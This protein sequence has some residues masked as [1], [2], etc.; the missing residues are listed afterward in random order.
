MPEGFIHKATKVTP[1]SHGIVTKHQTVHVNSMPLDT[2]ANAI[3][4]NKVPVHHR[5]L[6]FAHLIDS[7]RNN[8]T[9]SKV[10]NV[11]SML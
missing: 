7:T 2:I 1:V 3:E 10:S 4:R 9:N 5:W 11:V 8:F 6:D